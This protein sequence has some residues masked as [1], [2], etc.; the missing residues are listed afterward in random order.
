MVSGLERRSSAAQLLDRGTRGRLL[1]KADDLFLGVSLL[2][3]HPLVR[4]TLVSSDWP[5]NRG[6]GQMSLQSRR[7]SL[8]DGGG[9]CGAQAGV[10]GRP[11][12]P[13]NQSTPVLRTAGPWVVCADTGSASAAGYAGPYTPASSKASTRRSRPSSTSHTATAMTPAYSSRSGLPSLE[14]GD[15]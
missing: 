3:V 10:V 1:Q 8:R 7:A 4:W 13:S 9:R 15:E 11:A 2:L 5:G 6:T 14:F 12:P